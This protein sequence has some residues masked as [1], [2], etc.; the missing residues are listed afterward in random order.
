MEER[1]LHCK[2]AVGTA[3]L[4]FQVGCYL[5]SSL[6]FI[7]TKNTPN[8][9]PSKEAKTYLESED[10]HTQIQSAIKGSLT[11]LIKYYQY[12]SKSPYST[13]TL[14]FLSLSLS[15]CFAL[16]SPLSFT[17]SYIFVYSTFVVLKFL[18]LW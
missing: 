3:T 18:H 8:F 14:P 2:E 7:L 12:K 13:K 5:Y 10:I 1:Y 11:N 9:L 6:P 15:Y 4:V 16:F 17:I